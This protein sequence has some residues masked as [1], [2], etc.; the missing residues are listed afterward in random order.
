M[1]DIFGAPSGVV[2]SSDASESF[3]NLGD[4]AGGGES[5]IGAPRGGGAFQTC[6]TCL[7]GTFTDCRGGLLLRYVQLT[8]ARTF[9]Y[10]LS[11][12]CKS[13]FTGTYFVLNRN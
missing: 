11:W 9:M 4:N 8:C 10:S 7:A 2:R 5:N 12:A 1:E 13:A 3:V 6:P